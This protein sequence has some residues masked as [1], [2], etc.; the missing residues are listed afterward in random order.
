M[1]VENAFSMAKILAWVV[2][3]TPVELWGYDLLSV[4]LRFGADVFATCLKYC[5]MVVLNVGTRSL[6]EMLRIGT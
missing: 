3:T 5:S 6:L 2:Y 4:I 1:C